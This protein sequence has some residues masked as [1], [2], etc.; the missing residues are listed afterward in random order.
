M[1]ECKNEKKLISTLT[2]VLGLGIGNIAFGATLSDVPTKHWAYNSVNKLVKDGVIE[3]YGD[4][5]FKGDRTVTRY[6]FAV[7]VAKAIDNYNKADEKDKSE[8]LQLV[9]EFSKELKDIG[10]RLGA[11]EQKVGSVKF[12][13]DAR[14]RY[15]VNPG[16]N[17]K[18][19][20]AAS[21]SRIQERIR[22][23][24]DS[25]IDDHWSVSALWCTEYKRTK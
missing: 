1:E 16:L 8:I 21:V 2:L 7:A 20:G 15:Q 19:N 23:T 12:S 4:G 22:L 13:G 18:S 5:T 17:G 3:G 10:A 24:G 9:S 11:V 6:E 25:V 14:L